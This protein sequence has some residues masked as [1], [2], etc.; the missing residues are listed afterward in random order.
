MGREFYAW[1]IMGSTRNAAVAANCASA[2]GNVSEMCCAGVRMRQGRK[3]VFEKHCIN[4]N[5]AISNT[6]MRIGGMNV[7]IKCQGGDNGAKFIAAGI[8]TAVATIAAF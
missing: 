4:K 8:V 1:A 3:H 5:V 2:C 6:R 7:E